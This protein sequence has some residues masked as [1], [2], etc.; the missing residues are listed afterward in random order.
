VESAARVAARAAQCSAAVPQ[1]LRWDNAPPH[2]TDAARDAA[3]AAGITSAWLPSRSPEWNGCAEMWRELQ[4]VVAANRAYAS[5]EE[6]A[7]RAA[8]WRDDHT[9]EELRRIAGL[10]SSKFDWLPT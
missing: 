8:G 2:H 7:A 3:T 6:L 10:Q 1:L 5:V 9:P 4:R